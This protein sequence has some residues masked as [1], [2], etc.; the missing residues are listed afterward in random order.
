M[1]DR[2]L[3]IPA[4]ALSLLVALF[5][6]TPRAECGGTAQCI[7]VG[8]TREAAAAAHHG[9]GPDTF[10]MT[11]AR[12]DLG[13]AS[14]SRTIFVEAVLGPA[15]TVARLGAIR[16]EGP[17]A[18][19]FRI[20]GGT[21]SPSSGPVHGGAGCTIA[22]AF[23]PTS[24]GNKTAT[25]QV[26][27]DPPGCEGCIT[28]RFVTLV[29]FVGRPDPALDATVRGILSAQLG[30]AQR[31][32]K[33]QIANAQQRMESLHRRDA[34]PES[35][36]RRAPLASTL[37]SLATTGVLDAAA[38]AP[39]GSVSS[40]GAARF[41]L[42]GIASFGNRHDPGSS[43][44]LDFLTDG[45]SAGVDRAFG[46][47]FVAGF[48]LG[49]AR[50]RTAVGEDGS[51]SRARGGSAMAY[52]SFG[53]TPGLFIDALLGG[54]SLDLRSRRFLA[55]VSSFAEADRRGRHAFGSIATGFEW[56]DGLALLA[57]YARA[58][59][60]R[61]RFEAA[62]ESGPAGYALRYHGQVTSSWQGTFG[63]RAESARDTRFGRVVP[64]ARAEFR[65]AF[66]TT[67]DASITYAD[68]AQDPSFILA[69]GEEARN[70]LLLGLGADL[71][72]RGGLA[73]GVDYQLLRGSSR[74]SSQSIRLNV[75]QALDGRGAAGWPAPLPSRRS[76]SLQVQLDTGFGHDDNVTR[77]QAGASA[78]PDRFFTAS[79]RASDTF[80]ITPNSRAVLAGTLGAEKF[81]TYN[82]LSRATAGIEAE[83]QYRPSAAFAAPT[84]TVFARAATQQYESR[85]RD[86]ETYA[87]GLSV[88]SLVTDRIGLFGSVARSLGAARGSAFDANESSAKV[89][90]DYRFDA[91]RSAYLAGELRRG[92][93][94]FTAPPPLGGASKDG[95]LTYPGGGTA[96][97]VFATPQLAN[98]R[99]DARTAGATLGYNLSVG[100]RES[101]DFSWRHLRSVPRHASD[102][103]AGVYEGSGKPRYTVN[104][105]FV[106]Y[107]MSF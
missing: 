14:A 7:G 56:T 73:I 107:L 45:L 13:T 21:C 2:T 53:P 38:L 85:L 47:S 54:G 57:P 26:P 64:R 88:Q 50:D 25:V 106:A 100:P 10:T 29:G 101:L 49:A 5:P 34:A 89:N 9:L 62:T 35:A 17:D 46:E 23:A 79:V 92:D 58:D 15:G 48:A 11:F 1:A 76:G 6:D 74:D 68:L 3:S 69:S 44:A 8:P 63:L 93:A 51:R 19:Q 87:A 40:T 18:P 24:P 91:N 105:F 86:G 30:A 90:V 72:H 82:G 83:L 75:S 77:A 84:F 80:S 65:R 4:A 71:L 39:G 52:A 27:L 96:D 67:G 32:S 70:A 102:L 78:V 22:V 98:Y 61:E 104:Q 28:G 31:F 36:G 66:R 81:R 41:W 59:Y 37:A 43:P 60:S 97:D 99:V 95:T 94:V 33:S 12:Q 103:P 55:P 16:I 20:T 42:G